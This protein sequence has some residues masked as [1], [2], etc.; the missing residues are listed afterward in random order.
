MPLTQ[1]SEQVEEDKGGGQQ[2]AAAPGVDVVPLLAPLEP[3]A[4]AVLQERADQAEAGHVLQVLLCDAQELQAGKAMVR[5]RDGVGGGLAAAPSTAQGAGGAD[6]GI[7][8]EE[9]ETLR[10]APTPPL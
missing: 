1:L 5:Q 4:D 8:P 6:P 9:R 10:P 3:H 2:V 7:P